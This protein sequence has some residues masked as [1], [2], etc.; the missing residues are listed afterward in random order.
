[1][2]TIPEQAALFPPESPPDPAPQAAVAR[3]TCTADHPMVRDYRID[4]STWDH[5]DPQFVWLADDDTL[6]VWH[7]RH[8]LHFFHRP[9][10]APRAE[11]IAL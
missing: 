8:C 6:E 7:C 2:E 4:P 3:R 9:H 11:R 10:L 1:M 5:Q